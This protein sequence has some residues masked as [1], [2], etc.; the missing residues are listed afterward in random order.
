MTSDFLADLHSNV[1][2][3][4]A[5]CKL[6]VRPSPRRATRSENPGKYTGEA[7]CMCNQSAFTSSETWERRKSG[8]GLNEICC[9]KRP[10]LVTAGEFA[11]SQECCDGG[12]ADKIQ[13]RGGGLCVDRFV[14]VCR[15]MRRPCFPTRERFH[16]FRGC[17]SLLDQRASRPQA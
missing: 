14:T 5:G 11:Q 12:G 6:R 15:R 9:V 13:G 8:R 7:A 10:S 17:S 1:V 2:Q 3:T 16:S 4:R